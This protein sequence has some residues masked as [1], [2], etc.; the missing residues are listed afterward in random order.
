MPLGSYY[1]L[2]AKREILRMGLERSL[3]QPIDDAEGVVALGH[4]D[5]G[6]IMSLFQRYYP[7][8]L[9]EPAQLES[10]CIVESK[11]NKGVY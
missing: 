6:A 3:Y 7:D 2:R 1:R 4:P 11:M 9:F 10:G 8:N 5:T